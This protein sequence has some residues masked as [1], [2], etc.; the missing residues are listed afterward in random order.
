MRRVLEL[1]RETLVLVSFRSGRSAHQA[2]RAIEELASEKRALERRSQRDALTG[3]ANRGHGEEFLR[4]AAETAEREGLPIAVVLCDVDHFKLV[5]DGYGH[6][7]GDALLKAV[8]GALA[9]G[10]RQTD[11]VARWGGDEMLAILPDTDA[12]GAALVA[13]RMRARIH[14]LVVTGPAG[15][16]VHAGLSVGV[17]TAARGAPVTSLLA[18]ADAALYEAKRAGRNRVCAREVQLGGVAGCAA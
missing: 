5:N 16:A 18:A 13:E 17:G 10:V 12:A 4:G 3:I 7:T 2:E 8:A 15:E 9:D 14:Q 1:A 11:L 6:A